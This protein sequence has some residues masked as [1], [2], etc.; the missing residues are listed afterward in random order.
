MKKFVKF[1]LRSRETGDEIQIAAASLSDAFECVSGGE[2]RWRYTGET[3]SEAYPHADLL[4]GIAASLPGTWEANPVSA[5]HFECGYRLQQA[6]G[7]QLYLSPPNYNHKNKFQIGLSWNYVD[8]TGATIISRTTCETINVGETKTAAQI[9]AD[10][11]RRL[12]PNAQRE[13]G[14]AVARLDVINK[15]HN[16]QSE[17]YA[18]LCSLTGD[19]GRL[20]QHFSTKLPHGLGSLTVSYGGR[21]SF[22]LNSMTAERAV[23]FV[24][25]LQQFEG[26]IFVPST[27]P[28]FTA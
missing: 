7:L 20:A 16:A 13:H 10:I 14:A 21:V 4:E 23:D 24:K 28:T 15:A 18:A 6:N 9:A 8:N 26:F 22:D 1:I 12:L 11:V 25:L 2:D 5:S 19:D 3:H 17:A 27:E